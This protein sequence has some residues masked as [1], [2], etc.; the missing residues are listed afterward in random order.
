MKWRMSG[1]I[2]HEVVLN[3]D[4]MKKRKDG[5][6]ETFRRISLSWLCGREYV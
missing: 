6:N 2:R 1:L 4:I 5:V 3:Y